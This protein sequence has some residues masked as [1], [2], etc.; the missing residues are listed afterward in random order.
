MESQA[1]WKWS[2]LINSLYVCSSYFT[3][4]VGKQKYQCGMGQIIKIYEVGRANVWKTEE[5]KKW[6]NN[7]L[8]ALFN[9]C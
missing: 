8:L 3:D 6:S 7:G 5:K 9:R 4:T 2:Q 1:S